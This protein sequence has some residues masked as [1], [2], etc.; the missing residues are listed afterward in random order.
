MNFSISD[1]GLLLAFARCNARYFRPAIA[2]EEDLADLANQ[3]QLSH[4]CHSL[5]LRGY[6]K[7][8]PARHYSRLFSII[9]NLGKGLSQSSLKTL[10]TVANLKEMAATYLDP[11]NEDFQTKPYFYSYDDILNIGT[12]LD[13]ERY[14]NLLYQF[15]LANRTLFLGSESQLYAA[16]HQSK[17]RTLA[18]VRMMRHSCPAL[19][20]EPGF[21]NM[22]IR[23]YQRVIDERLQCINYS[24]NPRLYLENIMFLNQRPR[25]EVAS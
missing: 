1:F 7:P 18:L 2:W 4:H 13:F 11:A 19:D 16:T 8:V 3:Y 14:S 24:K 10:S 21:L 6:T 23:L 5:L 12:M 15:S 20:D 17:S 9:N 25:L 22:M